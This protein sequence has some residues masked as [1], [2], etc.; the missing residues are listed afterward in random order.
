MEKD[1]QTILPAHVRP[2]IMLAAGLLVTLAIAGIAWRGKVILL[3]L[4]GLSNAIW[5]F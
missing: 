2:W 1:E 5:C 4:A 3:D